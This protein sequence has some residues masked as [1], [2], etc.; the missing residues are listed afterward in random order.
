MF[1][2]SKWSV[3]A[4][5]KMPPNQVW[6]Q[7]SFIIGAIGEWAIKWWGKL[8]QLLRHR[9]VVQTCRPQQASGS[10]NVTRCHSYSSAEFR[11]LPEVLPYWWADLWHYVFCFWIVYYKRVRRGVQI[12]DMLVWTGCSNWRKVSVISSLF[13]PKWWVPNVVKWLCMYHCS[14]FHNWILEVGTAVVTWHSQCDNSIT[15]LDNRC[16]IKGFHLAR[17]WECNAQSISLHCFHSTA[18]T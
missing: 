4:S 14:L 11:C 8:V 13:Y 17:L 3:I 9:S 10:L 7:A 5:I 18:S 15:S 16:P 12:L 1:E 6:F 2:A